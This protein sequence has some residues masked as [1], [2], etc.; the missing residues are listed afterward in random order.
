MFIPFRQYQGRPAFA[1]PTRLRILNLLLAESEVCVCDFCDVLDVLQKGV[2]M[3]RDSVEQ[4]VAGGREDL[5]QLERAEIAIIEEFLPP[6][7][8][9]EEIRAAVRAAIAPHS[10]RKE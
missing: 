1:N 10:D 4:Y 6:A 7:A 5:A 9:P 3:R 8:D 2:K